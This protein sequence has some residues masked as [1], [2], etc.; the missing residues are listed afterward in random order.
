MTSIRFSRPVVPDAVKIQKYFEEDRTSG[1]ITNFSPAHKKFSYRLAEF[2]NLSSDRK[3][4]LTSSGH[5][6][7]MS[8]FNVL[9]CEKLLVPDFTFESTRAAAQLQNIDTLVVDVDP[10][11]GCLTRDILENVVA[12]YDSVVLVCALSTIPNLPEIASF[13]RQEG[14]KL[15]IDGAPTFGTPGIFNYGDAFCLSLHGTKSLPVGEGGAVIT[16]TNSANSVRQFINFGFGPDRRPVRPGMNAKMSGYAAAVGLSLMDDISN[17]LEVRLANSLI[18]LDRLGS[19]V[20]SS[21]VRRTVYAFMPIFMPS[22]VAASEAHKNLA[23]SGIE[24]KRYYFP[25][26]GLPV[27]SDLYERSVCVPCHQDVSSE[28]VHFICDIILGT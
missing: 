7:L 17:C 14:K 25:L 20:P 18:C 16:N 26:E 19:M 21:Y 6:A 12:E 10:I 1:H 28:Q 15:I 4:T 3:L 27:A 24:S 13:C 22:N 8:A 23:L 11:S 5:T 2:L 9:E